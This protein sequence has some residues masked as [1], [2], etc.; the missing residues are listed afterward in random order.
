[1]LFHERTG[2]RPGANVAGN[3]LQGHPLFDHEVR[4]GK[5][6]E[7]KLDGAVTLLDESPFRRPISADN[8]AVE[9]AYQRVD[10]GRNLEEHVRPDRDHAT[11][12]QHALDLVPEAR[13]LEPVDGLGRGHQIDGSVLESA[14]FGPSHPV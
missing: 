13:Q 1:M 6:G 9:A 11:W 7:W 4:R 3:V 8:A 5:L 14:L 10:V 2:C 12:P